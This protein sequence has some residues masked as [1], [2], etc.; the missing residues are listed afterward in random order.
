MWRYILSATR[1]L[2]AIQA[3]LERHE[4]EFNELRHELRRLAENERHE[5]EKFCLRLE[6]VL[7]SSERRLPAPAAVKKLRKR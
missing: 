3:T 7:L 5:R 2:F 6:N 1:K 4:Q